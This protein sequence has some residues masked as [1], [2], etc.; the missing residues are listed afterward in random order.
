MRFLVQC[1]LAASMVMAA[2]LAPSHAQQQRAQPRVVLSP[3][4]VTLLTD[5]IADPNSTGVQL[6]N[7]LA[8][9]LGQQGL[10]VLPI[11][12]EGGL[13]NIRDLL[14]LKG[15]DLAIL[16]SDILSYLDATGEFPD[17]RRRIR[18]VT[19]LGDQ[20]VY[21]LGRAN[22]ASINDLRSRRVAAL[23]APGISPVTAKTVFG[24]LKIDAELLPI[25]PAQLAG[26]QSLSGI[27]GVIMSAGDAAKVGQLANRFTDF[28]LVPI[29]AGPALTK[30]YS[31]YQI[32]ANELGALAMSS[33]PTDSIAFSTVLAVFDWT[34]Q[35]SRYANV[36]GFLK[37]FFQALP[38]LR[39]MAYAPLWRQANIRA[40]IPGWQR[41]AA[42]DPARLLSEAQLASLSAVER[43]R[44]APVV[45]SV[46]AVPEPKRPQGSGLSILAINRAPLAD[47]AERDG[48]LIPALMA[49]GLRAVDSDNSRRPEFTWVK[50]DAI[51]L[52]LLTNET[53]ADIMLP[54]DKADCD[55]P[56]ELTQTQAML[57]DRA[58]FSDPIMQV[59]IGLFT[60]A[61]SEFKF[62]TDA[63]I[64][65]RTICLP[66]DRDIADLA[67]PGRNWIAEKR[68]NL[69]RQP[70][71][72]DCIG[73][74]QRKEADA[75]VA[76]DLEGQN[77]LKRLGLSK[78]FTMAER[79]LGTR[80]IHAAVWKSHPQAAEMLDKVNK[81]IRQI[82]DNGAHASL[83]N[84]YMMSIWNSN[85]GVR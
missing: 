73:I 22:V 84:R 55:R 37:G 35:H 28:H 8:A 79:P 71:M 52:Q 6:V 11:A 61:D 15:V 59:V 58:T 47:E 68:I 48:G 80:T 14:Q 30:T 18:F 76:T 40:E 23:T 75:F 31:S 17:A 42:A 21:L 29:V 41:Y 74:V 70:T 36:N 53:A 69:I 85:T 1:V 65:G 64:F 2:T 60:G 45:A 49:A 5:G 46:A 43:A 78:L 44:P 10:R 66:G 38:T 3:E 62:P 4:R 26:D 77:V 51:S 39:T 25:T 83:V 82:K 19:H 50:P 56:S 63:S 54:W 67:S 20:P 13:G 32:P 27:D 81:A 24:L 33:G 7:D 16:N 72:L 57:C 9:R 34:P 12:G